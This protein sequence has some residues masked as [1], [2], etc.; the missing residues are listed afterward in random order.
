MTTKKTWTK[1][2]RFLG[3]FAFLF[4]LYYIG[5]RN[6]LKVLATTDLTPLLIAVSFNVP[7]VVFKTLRWQVLLKRAAIQTPFGRSYR[8]YFAS[9]FIGCLTPGR[10]GELIKAAYISSD[11]GVPW[12]RALPSVLIDRFF[13]LYILLMLGSVG[14]YRYCFD[15]RQAGWGTSLFLAALLLIT[16]L[17]F[18]SRR[19]M[20][21]IQRSLYLDK[22]REGWR[23]TIFEGTGQLAQLTSKALFSCLILTCIAY[24]IFF[25][26]CWLG[27]FSL[28]MKISFVDLI[29]IMSVTNLLSL[30]PISISGIG[31]RD[32]SLIVLLGHLGINNTQA[33]AFS[34]VVLLIFY[35]GGSF[36]GLI[37]WLWNPVKIE[38]SQLDN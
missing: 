33:L 27:T 6:L 30:V 34:L 11:A 8:A 13:D 24:A 19:I 25:V 32:V 23:E 5:P 28:E 18:G 10:L 21:W 12:R 26:Q 22:L 7:A 3:L 37:F 2:L 16:M 29:F 1:K 35:V 38:F 17:M 15:I 4:L 20:L 9:I 36:L 14:L 31:V